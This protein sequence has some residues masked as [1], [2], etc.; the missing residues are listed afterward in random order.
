MSVREILGVGGIIDAQF[1]PGGEGPTGAVGPV[2]PTGPAGGPTGPA[3]PTGAGATGPTGP[4]GPVGGVGPTGAG[5]TGPTGP[6]GGLGLTGPTGP[7]GA[8]ATGPVG[9]IGPTGPAG[10]G[11]PVILRDFYAGG[12]FPSA[13]SVGGVAI[14]LG[15]PASVLANRT[16]LLTAVVYLQSTGSAP[17]LVGG[18]SAVVAGY[19]QSLPILE[20]P[21]SEMDAPTFIQAT[22][23]QVIRIPAGATGSLQLQVG[24]QSGV[25]NI[26]GTLYNFALV[27]LS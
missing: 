6:V 14:N 10:F 16:Y 12:T 4:I 3:G 17:N 1:L 19:G 9:P 20:S 2:G 21:E 11:T 8:G 25:G 26:T 24:G 22:V 7:T 23:A 5:A 18:I 13:T 27:P 15:P